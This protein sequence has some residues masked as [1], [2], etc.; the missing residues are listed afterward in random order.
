MII[1]EPF[2]EAR[3]GLCSATKTAFPSWN[4]LRYTQML[5]TRHFGRDAEIQRPGWQT[6]ADYIA[7]IKHLSNRQVTVHG[8]DTGSHAGMTAFLARQD[9]C[10][11]AR[12]GNW[13]RPKKKIE[14]RWRGT[15]SG[16]LFNDGGHTQ[17]PKAVVI[18]TVERIAVE[19][20]RGAAAAPKIVEGPAAQHPGDVGI[21]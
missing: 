3:P 19:A 14:C 15:F 21:G 20:E 8:L 11:T 18:V 10:I 2:C 1:A 4:S 13:E 16:Q 6:L 9:L 17:Q 7:Q 12:Y 5:E